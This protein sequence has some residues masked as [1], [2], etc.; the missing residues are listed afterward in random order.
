MNE[1]SLK[2]FLKQAVS[3]TQPVAV[4]NNQ[5]TPYVKFTT[6]T[7]TIQRTDNVYKKRG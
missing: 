5:N 2:Q 1:E 7:P 6:A 3:M 4:P